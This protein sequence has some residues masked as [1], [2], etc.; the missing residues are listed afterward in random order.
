ML[1]HAKIHLRDLITDGTV[2]TLQTLRQ[3]GGRSE[4]VV[5]ASAEATKAAR[6][7]ATIIGEKGLPFVRGK[8]GQFREVMKEVG[9]GRKAIAGAAAVSTIVISAAHMISA[10]DLARTLNQVDQKLDLLHA[11]RQI[12]QAATLERIYTSARELLASP[13]DE[14]RRIHDLQTWID[15]M[16]KSR[17]TGVS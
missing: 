12:D 8:T 3:W 1:A 5:A 11:Y 9:R 2:V 15:E 16:P 10:A 7:G 4:M 6:T 14:V 13:L 17:I